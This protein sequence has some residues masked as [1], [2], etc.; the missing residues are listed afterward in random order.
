MDGSLPGSSVHGIPQART[1]E[2]VAGT[3]HAWALSHIRLLA[4]SWTIVNQ[5]PLSTGFSRQTYWGGLQE[6]IVLGHSVIPDSMDYSPP[7]S[8]VHGILQARILYRVAIS[9]CRQASWPRD[10][11]HTSCVSCTGGRVLCRCATWKA[12]NQTIQWVLWA[13]RYLWALDPV[14]QS[15]Q[16]AWEN[17][18]L[19]GNAEG[20][21]CTLTGMRLRK[22]GYGNLESEI[23]KW[24]LTSHQESDGRNS[25]DTER[26]SESWHPMKPA[27]ELLQ[28]L[29][30]TQPPMWVVLPGEKRTTW[31]KLKGGARHTLSHLGI[32]AK[33]KALHFSWQ[34]AAA[35]WVSRSARAGGPTGSSPLASV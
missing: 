18:P 4:M 22:Q 32:Q 19:T 33:V 20:M 12:Q 3:N 11:T 16:Q 15:T 6:Q 8:S 27:A 30:Q 29:R 28:E 17:T 5:A 23:G 14:L 21:F 7:G 1:A 25:L 35:L 9:S 10:Q 26:H 13:G 2:W 34:Q 24:A 31:T